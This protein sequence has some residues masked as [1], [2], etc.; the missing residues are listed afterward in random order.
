M[1]IGGDVASRLSRV[2]FAHQ[3]A[4]TVAYHQRQQLQQALAPTPAPPPAFAPQVQAPD[5]AHFIPAS[6]PADSQKQQQQKQ[7]QQQ[8]QQQHLWLSQFS[9]IGVVAG[10]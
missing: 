3:D 10:V 6:H 1:H 7:Q 2:P 5:T 9:S 8:Q 4:A